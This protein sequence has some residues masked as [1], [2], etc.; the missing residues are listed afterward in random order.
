[1][2]VGAIV[3]TAVITIALAVALTTLLPGAGFVG[4]I[5]LVVAG[6]AM[7]VWLLGAAGSR[8]VPSE[9]A[10]DT[11]EREFFRPWWAR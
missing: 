2:S 6:I 3:L 1:V 9:L 10:R 8:R 4:A 11:K 7:I 5:V